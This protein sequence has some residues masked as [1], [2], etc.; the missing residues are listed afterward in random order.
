MNLRQAPAVSFLSGFTCSL[1]KLAMLAVFSITVTLTCSAGTFSGTLTTNNSSLTW[2]S[3]QTGVIGQTQTG[4]GVL[5]PPCNAT[6]CDLYNLVVN[7]PSTFYA[8]NPNFAIHVSASWSS[9]LN[10]YDLYIYDSNNNLVGMA[11]QGGNTFNDADLG[12]LP[13]G[14]YQVQVVPTIAANTPYTG[15]I[16]LAAEPTM[17]T[18]R[19]RYKLGNATFSAQML[20][21]PPQVFNTATPVFLEQDAEPRVVH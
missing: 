4:T 16:T 10:E 7:V 6:V 18:G 11:T 12:Q 17:A 5:N 2:T 14:A 13:S 21:R 9:S 3:T 1:G 8:A 19:A 20:T 15:T